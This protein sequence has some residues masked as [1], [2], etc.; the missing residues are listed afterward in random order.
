M[1]AALVVAFV[2]Q[3]LASRLRMALLAMIVGFPLLA[4]VFGSGDIAQT[5]DDSYAVALVLAAGMIGQDFSS[6]TI[7]LLLAR[8][9]T[10]PGYV[11]SRWAGVT[12]AALAVLVFELAVGTL[13]LAARNRLPVP[14]DAAIALAQGALTA[15]GTAAV[16]ALAS[17]LATGFGD[18]ALLLATALVGWSVSGIGNYRNWPVAVRI[19]EEVQRFITPKLELAPLLDGR[20]PWYDLTT[21][22]STVAMCLAFAIVVV[23][24]RELSY[25]SAG[26]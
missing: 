16:M 4:L 24:R 25:A 5:L 17:A 19:G 8:P 11:L 15:A 1:N 7:Q 21:Y 20:V 2:R 6:G 23:N 3:R 13:A 9:V 22:L 14:A 12:L 26:T 10:R 18:L